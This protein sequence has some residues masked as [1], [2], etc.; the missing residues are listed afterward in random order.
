[1]KY[2][3]ENS[4]NKIIAR[5]EQEADRDICI[6]ALAEYWDDCVFRATEPD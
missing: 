2:C 1:M 3:I 4:E 6:D 5:F